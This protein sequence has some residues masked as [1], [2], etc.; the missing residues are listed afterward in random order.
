MD[1]KL[2]KDLIHMLFLNVT[3][4]QL[5]EANGVR[6]HEYALRKDESS[7]LRRALD[8]R[9]NGTRKRG[10]P[11]RIWKKPLHDRVEKLD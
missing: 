2:T 8:L 7:F 11:K 9:V 3:M 5:A 6:W 1:K 4:D 10:R